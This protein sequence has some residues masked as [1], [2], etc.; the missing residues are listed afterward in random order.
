M[1]WRLGQG[2]GLSISRV[3]SSEPPRVLNESLTE[4]LP[5]W[6]PDGAW[7][8]YRD[9][10]GL[11]LV[12]PDGEQR[13]LVTSEDGA[14]M[15][16]SADGRTIYAQRSDPLALVAIDVET[17]REQTITTFASDLF[18]GVPSNPGQRF[19]LSSDGQSLLAS[20]FRLRSD[21]WIL[22]GFDR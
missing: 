15:A 6:S 2:L 18:L 3:G 9:N 16:W 22:D 5:A 19:T 1:F 8:A 20:G 17:G 4:A 11:K 13:R 21:I 7:I 10:D 14:T 12:S